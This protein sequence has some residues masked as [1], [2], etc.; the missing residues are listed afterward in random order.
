MEDVGGE[1]DFDDWL[2]SSCRMDCGEESTAFAERYAAGAG[3]SLRSEPVPC[4]T[5][6]GEG[7]GMSST[8]EMGE[9]EGKSWSRGKMQKKKKESGKRKREEGMVRSS[10]KHWWQ[11]QG[12]MQNIHKVIQEKGQRGLDTEL[13]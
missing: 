8:C 12:I 13:C 5:A 1:G 9:T 7:V 2:S 3:V 11:I 4:R 10:G 6:G